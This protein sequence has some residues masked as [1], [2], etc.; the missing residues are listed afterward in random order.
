MRRVDSNLGFK[1]WITCIQASHI[2]QMKGGELVEVRMSE[3]GA[4]DSYS[5]FYF[6]NLH[7]TLLVVQLVTASISECKWFG[8]LFAHYFRHVSRTDERGSILDVLFTI[9][10]VSEYHIW[11]KVVDNS[12]E[13]LNNRWPLN[14]IGKHLYGMLEYVLWNSKSDQLPHIPVVLKDYD[15]GFCIQIRI[16][17]RSFHNN[18]GTYLMFWNLLIFLKDLWHLFSIHFSF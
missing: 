15:V 2:L 6:Y 14:S 4:F 9:H 12:V 7:S 18:I 16:G 11:C 17:T 5:N 13:N 1:T 10:Q 8:G 3:D